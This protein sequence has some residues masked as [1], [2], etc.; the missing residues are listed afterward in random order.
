MRLSP[1]F[2]LDVATDNFVSCDCAKTVMLSKADSFGTV[3]VK[4]DDEN[5]VKY[6][7]KIIEL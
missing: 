7:L 3:F 1:Q 4:R 2:I 5:K 6:K